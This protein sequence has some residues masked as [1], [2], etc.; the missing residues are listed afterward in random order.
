MSCRELSIIP[1]VELRQA[2]VYDSDRLAET[3]H[4]ADAIINMVGIL[5]ESGRR[6]K[7]FHKAHVDLVER[8]IDACRASGTSRL[9][10]VSALN[11]GRG[12]SHYLISKGQAEERISAA[13]DIGST[14]LQPSVIFGAGDDFFNRFAALLRT[15][16]VLPLACPEARMQPVW[17][18][19]VATMATLALADDSTI[20]ETLVLVGPKAYSLRELVEFTARTIGRKPRILGLPD[21][22]SRLQGRLM[23][24]VPGKPFSTDNYLSLQVDNVSSENCLPRFG[25]TPRSIESVVP[26]YLAASPRQQRLDEFRRQV[27]H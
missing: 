21:G 23:D 13:T 1:R 5:N 6:G 17:V 22:L 9:V 14:I 2:D 7:G 20:G 4:G 15:V 27:R 3:F 11:A 12:K 8:V 24:F 18:G 26:A 10:H 16:P 19:D 25:I